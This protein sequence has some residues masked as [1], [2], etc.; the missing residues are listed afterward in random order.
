LAKNTKISESFIEF[1]EIVLQK[2]VFENHESVAEVDSE[3]RKKAAH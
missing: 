3:K 2:K 1:G